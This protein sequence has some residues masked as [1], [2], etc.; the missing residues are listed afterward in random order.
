M[1]TETE[2]QFIIKEGESG[3]NY[4]PLPADNYPGICYQFIHIGHIV[5][6]FNEGKIKDVIQLGF[7]IPG[8]RKVF[9]EGGQ[10]EP[11]RVSQEFT[12]SL[13]K[14]ATLRQFLEAWRGKPFTAEELQGFNLL[15]LIGA[16]CMLNIV[17]KEGTGEKVG[18]K[19][20]KIGSVAKLAKGMEKPAPF[21]A[22]QILTYTKWNEEVFN[23]LP[24]YVQEKIKGSEE[25]IKINLLPMPKNGVMKEPAP[26]GEVDDLPF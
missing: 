15:K 26:I 7:E 14:K 20:L 5:D 2:E 18:K 3:T 11:Y 24:I 10:E 22:P 19:Y 1:S 9:K 6:K 21:M 13:H 8:E 25:Y 4:E 12:N 17:H 23:N 16:P